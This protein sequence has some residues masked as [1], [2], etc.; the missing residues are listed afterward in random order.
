MNYHWDIKDFTKEGYFYR[1]I[2]KLWELFKYGFYPC[3][4]GDLIYNT[5][6]KIIETNDKSEW[7][8]RA[9]DEC[10]VL[11]YLD[12]RWP[13]YMNEEVVGDKYRSQY[14]MTR[15]PYILFYACA[16]HLDERRY[17]K[18]KPPLRLYTPHVWAWRR[19]LLGK[20]NLYWLWK[21]VMGTPKKEF[22]QVLRYY[23]DWSYNMVSWFN[24]L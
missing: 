22:V 16:I 13:D 20:P 10:A 11:L 1:G 9:L 5:L 4:M 8:H 12:K 19:V 23:Q 6:R 18:M 3:G 2:K 24:N 14:S 15:D 7:A 21:R 17:I